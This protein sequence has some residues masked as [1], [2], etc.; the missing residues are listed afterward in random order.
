[1]CARYVHFRLHDWDYFD[2]LRNLP[3]ERDAHATR[4]PLRELQYRLNPDRDRLLRG[5]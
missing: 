2:I 1:M 4:E 3:I 5:G